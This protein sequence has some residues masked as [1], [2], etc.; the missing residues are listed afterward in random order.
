M[1][2][3][4]FRNAVRDALDEELARDESVVFFGEDVAA[5]G[6]VFAVTP[7]LQ[8][9]AIREERSLPHR[10]R[11]QSEDGSVRSPPRAPATLFSRT[12]GRQKCRIRGDAG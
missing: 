4:E 3:L 8:E 10:K 1:S 11:A 2:E 5:P 9:P 12:D 7:G 6:G